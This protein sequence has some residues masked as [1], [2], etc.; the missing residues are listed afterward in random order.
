MLQYPLVLP[1]ADHLLVAV[2][3]HW[4]SLRLITCWWLS[5]NDIQDKVHTIQISRHI[6]ADVLKGQSSDNTKSPAQLCSCYSFHWCCLRLITCW[7]LS[8][9]DI[10]GTKFR[11][12]EIS[13]HSCADVTVPLVLPE[14][15]HLLVAVR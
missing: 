1:E 7:W 3:F 8:G 4:C 14:A 6:C 9:N 10:Q 2:R 5:G 15:D 13:R 12:Y 11:Q